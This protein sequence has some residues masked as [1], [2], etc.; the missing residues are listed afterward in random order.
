MTKISV[1]VPIYNAEQYLETCLKSIIAQSFINLEIILVDDGSTDQSLKICTTYADRDSRITVVH[2]SN[3]GVSSAR[4]TGIS[5]AS[6]TYVSFVDADD[7]L[8]ADMYSKLLT[9]IEDISCDMVSCGFAVFPRHN[10]K[11]GGDI[12]LKVFQ[13]NTDILND[14]LTRQTGGMGVWNKLFKRSLIGDIRFDT[15]LKHNED[16]L[17]LFEIY[18]QCHSYSHIT[19]EGYRYY[20]REGSASNSLLSYSFFDVALVAEI[21]EQE[22]SDGD[23]QRTTQ[24][25]ARQSSILALLNLYRTMTLSD[26]LGDFKI[27]YDA[28]RRKILGYDLN[29]ITHINR[30][31]K[32]ELSLL[33]I[34]PQLYM[35]A[36]RHYK[37]LIMDAKHE[38]S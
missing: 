17:F 31:R 18:K 12:Q 37:K 27:E 34:S 30:K 20:N 38:N 11:R 15:S 23:Y 22:I 36:T 14:F 16:K 13:N 1:I 24:H 10:Q 29:G 25:Y 26:N 6:G 8:E 28:L 4:N 7:S 33:R 21:I 2:T 35:A 5:W 3:H 19:Y 9:V 32:L